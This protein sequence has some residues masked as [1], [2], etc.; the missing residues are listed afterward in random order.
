MLRLAVVSLQAGKGQGRVFANF[1]RQSYCGRAGLY[2]AAVV[3]HVELNKHVNLAGHAGR[4]PPLVHASGQTANAIHA[5]NTN[6]QLAAQR[7]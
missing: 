5:V 6:G 3:A 4:Q 7:R 2:A 1:K